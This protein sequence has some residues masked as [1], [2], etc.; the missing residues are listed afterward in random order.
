ME[1]SI[2]ISKEVKNHFES[3]VEI[4]KTRVLKLSSEYGRLSV[5][6]EY[7]YRDDID[8]AQCRRWNTLNPNTTPMNTKPVEGIHSKLRYPGYS[9]S[10]NSNPLKNRAST[11]KEG[12]FYGGGGM[13]MNMNMNMNMKGESLDSE[14]TAPF[15]Q[16]GSVQSPGSSSPPTSSSE[17]FNN[18]LSPPLVTNIN[19][20][21][22]LSKGLLS[23]P[24]I[25]P[26][27]DFGF[28]TP[29]P[30]H[31]P[32]C[33]S[34]TTS[35]N[36]GDL[37]EVFKSLESFEEIKTR[38]RKLSGEDSYC[39]G[40]GLSGNRERGSHF[41]MRIIEE[42]TGSTCVGAA[43]LGSVS[44][45]EMDTPPSLG[46]AI[47]LTHHVPFHNNNNIHPLLMNKVFYI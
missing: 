11:L 18:M 13:N 35:M 4:Q 43:E 10:R 16:W 24:H 19:T 9:S 40:S 33:R 45:N 31:H 42:G 38:T 28:K 29:T 39:G 27:K 6:I 21:P 15:A 1:Y 23:R 25:H 8:N 22:H 37:S 17:I 30:T 14:P 2:S 26:F 34:R 36:C 44:D 20:H 12:H 3:G 41:T 5:H 47:P 7:L 46:G 32:S